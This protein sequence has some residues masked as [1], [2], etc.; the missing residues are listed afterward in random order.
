MRKF[1]A[2]L[3]A[4]V[5]VATMAA[6]PADAGGKKSATTS[7][8]WTGTDDCT[9]VLSFAWANYPSGPNADYTAYVGWKFDG[10]MI[11]SWALS[12]ATGTGSLGPYSVNLGAATATSH[13]LT[14]IYWLNRNGVK[15]PHTVFESTVTHTTYCTYVD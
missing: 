8:G 7:D 14:L 6:A 4:V 10:T 1:M 3:G 13:T 11:S 5:L 12:Q 9:L 2:A 15:A